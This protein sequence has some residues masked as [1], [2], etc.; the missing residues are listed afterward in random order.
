MDEVIKESDLHF[1]QKINLAEAL[2]EMQG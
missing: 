2:D 1:K